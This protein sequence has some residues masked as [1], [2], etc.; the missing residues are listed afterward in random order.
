MSGPGSIG[1]LVKVAVA[2]AGIAPARLRDRCA[3]RGP[4]AEADEP[5]CLIASH[6]HVPVPVSRAER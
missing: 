5:S 3:R 4:R 2:P 1:P 6:V